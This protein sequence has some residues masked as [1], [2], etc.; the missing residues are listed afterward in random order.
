MYTKANKT[1][2]KM[3]QLD[4]EQHP[5]ATASPGAVYTV[6]GGKSSDIFRLPSCLE[7]SPG[8]GRNRRRV[9]SPKTF[10][11]GVSSR[12]ETDLSSRSSSMEA[13][14]LKWSQEDV[15]TWLVECGFEE[16]EVSSLETKAEKKPCMY[17]PCCIAFA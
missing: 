7:E 4:A 11:G 2:D 17:S 15:E 6:I 14:V 5:D 10:Q 13:E 12:D 1:N 3:Q 16:Y 8:R 9:R